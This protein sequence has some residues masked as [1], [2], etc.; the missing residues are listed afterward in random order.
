MNR[1][2]TLQENGFIVDP[3]SI[4]PRSAVAALAI[5]SSSSS[6][7]FIQDN[8]GTGIGSCKRFAIGNDISVSQTISN[9]QTK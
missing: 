3:G 6:T 5:Y 4:T 7:V 1:N 2:S 8:P 9:S